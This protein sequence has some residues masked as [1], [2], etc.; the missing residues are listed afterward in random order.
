MEHTVFFPILFQTPE[1]AGLKK[2]TKWPVS[3][4]TKVLI[5]SN[6]LRIWCIV[7]QAVI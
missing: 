1:M 2:I 7:L 5:S 6:T 4:K 3:D